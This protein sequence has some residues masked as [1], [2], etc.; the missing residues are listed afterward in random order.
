MENNNK[1]K[2]IIYISQLIKFE[3]KMERIILDN[4]NLISLGFDGIT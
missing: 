1:K 2:K 4:D 3:R